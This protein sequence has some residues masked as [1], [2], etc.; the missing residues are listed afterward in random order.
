MAD[1]PAVPFRL[2]SR[3]EIDRARTWIPQRGSLFI[4]GT[5]SAFGG[6]VVSR[7]AVHLPAAEDVGEWVAQLV[8]RDGPAYVARAILRSCP[9]AAVFEMTQVLCDSHF[10]DEAVSIDQGDDNLGLQ[11]CRVGLL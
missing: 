8:Q 3:E 1:E 11:V 7:P 2:P 10:G 9:P 5:S 4:P 6:V